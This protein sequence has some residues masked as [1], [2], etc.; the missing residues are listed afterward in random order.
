MSFFFDFGVSVVF[1]CKLMM[2]LVKMVVGVRVDIVK[3]DNKVF[4]N[5]VCSSIIN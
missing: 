2:F 3:V 4:K 5:F 1:K